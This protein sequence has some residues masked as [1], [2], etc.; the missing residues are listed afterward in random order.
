MAENRKAEK[1]TARRASGKEIAESALSPRVRA[2]LSI[3]TASGLI[4]GKKG[5]RLSGRV[6]EDLFD[7]AVAKS[8]LNGADLIDYALAKVALEDDFAEQ[9]IALRGS[10]S[11]DVDLDA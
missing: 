6:H 5:K 11:K 3:A 2:T 10:I 9:L 7:A 8:G 1:A 4:K